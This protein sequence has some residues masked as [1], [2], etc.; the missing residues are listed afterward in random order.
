MSCRAVPLAAAC[1]VALVGLVACG[2]EQTTEPSGTSP[3]LEHVHGLG[4]DPADG[5]LYA[6]THHG[7]FRIAGSKIEGPIADL[8]QDFMGF[9]VAGPHHFLASGHPG[10]GQDAPAALG[11]LESTDGGESWRTRSLAGEADCHAL[12]YRHDTAYCLNSMTGELLASPDLE[13]WEVRTRMPFLDIAI[14]PSSSDE[15]LVTSE[16]GPLLSVDGGRS[17][18]PVDGAP[19]LVFVEWLHDGTVVGVGP[20]GT[21]LIRSPGARQFTTI[22]SMHHVPEA[23]HAAS[24]TELYAS[25]GGRLW[26]ST[27]GGKSFE[28]LSG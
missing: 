3:L 4:V 16:Q 8:E 18:E 24:P 20:D 6:G 10:A 13:N 9:T 15:L 17:F 1:A 2:G 28:A 25:I 19:L 22:G 14:G 5:V 11:L 26:A 7:L 12:A 23:F 27:D 21:V